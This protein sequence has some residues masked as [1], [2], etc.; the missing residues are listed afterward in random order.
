MV[1]VDEFIQQPGQKELLLR[2]SFLDNIHVAVP[3]EILSYN[4]ETR[5]A[6]I[7]PVIR[8]WGDSKEPPILVDV[9]VFFFG[10]FVFDVNKGD[11]CLVVFA[12]SC[13]DA[14]FANSGV[15]VPVSA[16]KHD[17]SDGFAFV[18][19][20]SRKNVTSGINLESKLE[21]LERRIEA[22]EGDGT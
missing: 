4:P 1:N 5:T 21:E 6:Q 16:R 2:N 10:N 12:D 20:R 7:Q 9:P 3:G 8:K 18:G 22:L 17:M 19:F 13:I 14:W 15:S 11:E